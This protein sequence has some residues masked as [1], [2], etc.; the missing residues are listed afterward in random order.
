MKIIAVVEAEIISIIRSLKLKGSKG[1]DDFH[2]RILGHCTFK[3]RKPLS[4]MCSYSLQS[5]IY[6]KRLKV[7]NS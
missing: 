6:P 7:F 1:Y 5:H 3:V 4:Y 2:S